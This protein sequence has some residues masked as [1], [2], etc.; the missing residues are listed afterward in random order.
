M[1]VRFSKGHLLED[2]HLTEQAIGLYVDAVQLKQKPNLPEE[3]LLHVQEC[4]DCRDKIVGVSSFLSGVGYTPAPSRPDERVVEMQKSVTGQWQTYLRVAAVILLF[5]GGAWAVNYMMRRDLGEEAAPQITE[6]PQVQDS[7]PGRV[8]DGTDELNGEGLREEP[9][10]LYAA[11]FEMNET[12][13]SFVGVSLRSGSI[14][15]II[16]PVNNELIG[17]QTLFAWKASTDQPLSLAIL[18]NRAAEVFRIAVTGDRFLLERRLIP[19]LYYWK[20]EEEDELLYLGRFLV[21]H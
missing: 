3:V 19:G 11:N 5:I 17:D 14:D 9:A 20:L 15:T 1:D 12:L 10:E 7:L 4:F 18:N 13:E 6:T 8:A 21:R 2:G 16:S